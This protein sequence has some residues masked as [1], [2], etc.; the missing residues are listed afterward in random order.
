M[1]TFDT[2]YRD[3]RLGPEV[4]FAAGGCRPGAALA[5]RRPSGLPVV[6]RQLSER[7]EQLLKRVMQRTLPAAAVDREVSVVVV[8]DGV[9]EMA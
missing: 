7:D 2:Q 5:K 8:P 3:K 9:S 4:R 1:S 6:R